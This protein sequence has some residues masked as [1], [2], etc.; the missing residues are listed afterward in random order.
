[1]QYLNFNISP[2]KRFYTFILKRLI[3]K[4]LS[5]SL[6]VSQLDIQITQGIVQLQDLSLDCHVLNELIDGLPFKILSAEVDK[7]R[8]DIP[9]TDLW[10]KSC[11]LSIDGLLIKVTPLIDIYKDEFL[12]NN[13][14]RNNNNHHHRSWLY[15]LATS[16]SIEDNNNN[17][18]ND[19]TKQNIELYRGL[20]KVLS[21][22]Q[23]YHYGV[24]TKEDLKYI[25]SPHGINHD[26]DDNDDDTDSD[27]EENIDSDN[28]NN[29]NNDDND[30]DI[31]QESQFLGMQ[32]ISDLVE[33]ILHNLKIDINNT[34]FIITHPSPFDNNCDTVLKLQLRQLNVSNI[35][36]NDNDDDD[37][38]N[39][40]D[41][42]DDDDDDDDDE[43]EEDEEEEE[44]HEN[45]KAKLR[46]RIKFGGL[47]V[48]L[49][50]TTLTE[51]VM[52]FNCDL[53]NETNVIIHGESEEIGQSSYIDIEA[54]LENNLNENDKYKQSTK[55]IEISGFIRTLRAVFNPLQLTLFLD[56]C[57]TISLSSELVAKIVQNQQQ[58]QQQQNDNNNNN[59]NNKPILDFQLK[60][61]RAILILLENNNDTIPSDWYLSNDD[62]LHQKQQK[63]SK[64]RKEIN[65]DEYYLKLIASYPWIPELLSSQIA[66]EL[67]NIDIHF[68]QI[69][70]QA[71]CAINIGCVEMVEFLP[72]NSFS[73]KFIKSLK[74]K[75]KPRQMI[76]RQ[77]LSI[78]ENDENSLEDW[79]PQITIS[80]RNI[81]RQR[82]DINIE[83]QPAKIDLD[84]KLFS[85]LNQ[86]SKSFAF[87]ADIDYSLPKSFDQ[88]LFNQ[89][90]EE[91]QKYNNNNNDII[92]TINIKTSSICV[93]FSVNNEYD[94]PRKENIL[95][96]FDELIAKNQSNLSERKDCDIWNLDCKNLNVLLAYNNTKHLI[97]KSCST[98]LNE[99][100]S[101]KI[102]INNNN[103]NNNN[104]NDNVENIV[105]DE[106]IMISHLEQAH[107]R[108]WEKSNNT[109]SKEIKFPRGDKKAT[110]QQFEFKAKSLSPTHVDIILPKA[111]VA[112]SKSVKLSQT[113]I[114][115]DHRCNII[116]TICAYIYSNMIY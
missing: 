58:Q 88:Q 24:Q 44:N 18:N 48:E 11:K 46:K 15:E 75:P 21:N 110:S 71:V 55:K 73:N 28:D 35:P 97:L 25:Q 17:N 16:L 84:F 100:N 2:V 106:D 102:Y 82:N 22:K 99:N 6:D 7:I 59:N 90:Q 12:F 26:N 34:T 89:Q 74:E 8:I 27:N 68:Q 87:I 98:F 14:N 45:R 33:R 60:I 85:R 57:N 52:S 54:P 10:N 111:M 86:I 72:I 40:D 39:D 32:F 13:N 20:H 67:L 101:L 47:V 31:N 61:H 53:M 96:E 78:N 104:N 77:I 115:I 93:R 49:F 1:M 29:N 38:S 92:K 43:E 50:H 62:K 56:L 91:E 64:K 42:Y 95:F 116:I 19:D 107:F 63:H 65:D 103:N 23:F 83:I 113:N 36:I 5:K 9:I 79:K 81:Y 108:W 4:F 69:P 37:D 76:K 3:G 105:D 114:S 80:I 94:I 41:E 70:C 51:S 66:M 30:N 109:K 112:C